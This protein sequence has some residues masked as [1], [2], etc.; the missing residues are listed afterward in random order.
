MNTFP[1]L[2]KRERWEHPAFWIVPAAFAGFVLLSALMAVSTALY[3]FGFP[4]TDI[5]EFAAEAI[6]IA[7]E[8]RRQLLRMGLLSLAVPFNIFLVGLMFFYALGSLYDD[9]RDRSILFWKSLPVSDVETVMSKFATALVLAPLMTF[10]VIVVVHLLALVV[11]AGIVLAAG[12]EGWYLV[13]DPIAVGYTW[14]MLLWGLL[15]QSLVFMPF[16][17]WLMLA[18]AW[19]KK[20]PFLWAVVPPAAVMMLEAWFFRDSHLALWIGNRIDKA[21]PMA[22]QMSERG[23]SVRAHG[24][25]VFVEGAL[26][27]RFDLLWSYE[28]WSGVVISAVLLVG[29]VWLRRYR[30]EAE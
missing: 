29:A 3:Q 30:A 6:T 8:D 7:A 19:A 21:L 13:F 4:G 10:A 18:S 1:A 15:A 22:F 26:Q 11:G 2:I 25:D 27:M 5:R 9:R 12:G 20:A 14:A 28:L 23:F 17:A 24:E 16:V